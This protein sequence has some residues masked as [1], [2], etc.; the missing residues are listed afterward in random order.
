[1]DQNEKIIKMKA[2]F[3][4]KYLNTPFYS[5]MLDQCELMILDKMPFKGATWYNGNNYVIALQKDFLLTASKEELIFMLEHE[6]HHIIFGHLTNRWLAELYGKGIIVNIC[7]DIAIHEII[8]VPAS[9]KKESMTRKRYGLDY[10]KSTEHYISQIEEDEKLKKRILEEFGNPIAITLKDLLSGNFPSGGGNI[11]IIISDSLDEEA[12]TEFIEK[13]GKLAGSIPS[14]IERMIDAS[15]NIKIKSLMN[16]LHNIA[17][18]DGGHGIKK[19]WA[20]MNYR[21]PTFRGQIRKM[22][23]SVGLIFDTSG[24]ID[25]K[26]LNIMAGGLR[27]VSQYCKVYVMACDATVHEQFWFKGRL[28]Q[29]TG[30]GGTV[31]HDAFKIAE[32]MK[33][34]ALVILT[35]GYCDYPSLT[36]IKHVFWGII[37]NPNF[38]PIFGKVF[39]LKEGRK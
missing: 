23:P 20:R 3:T 39:N 12:N 10:L 32:R 18:E 22:Q 7:A 29:I 8:D 17:D 11:D 27:S 9:M 14:D 1:M 38:E 5:I 36:S 28:K 21:N 26:A 2:M 37:D 31:F 6:L 19:T 34:K 35:D 15:K 25:A 30:G 4:D 33:L 13:V 16:S 24:S